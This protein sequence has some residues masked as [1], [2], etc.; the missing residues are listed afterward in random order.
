[1]AVVVAGADFMIASAKNPLTNSTYRGLMYEFGDY[2][3]RVQDPL[4]PNYE[5][6]TRR[7]IRSEYLGPSNC[8]YNEVLTDINTWDTNYNLCSNNCQDFARELAVYLITDCEYQ[9]KRSLRA[10]DDDNFAS[11]NAKHQY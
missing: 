2:G 4:D 9:G 7:I 6:N 1:M 10:D 8:T 11:Y 3:V 5:Y